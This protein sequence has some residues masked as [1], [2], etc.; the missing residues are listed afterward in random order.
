MTTLRIG[1]FNSLTLI[2]HESTNGHF[3]QFLVNHLKSKTFIDLEIIR[4]PVQRGRPPINSTR[5]YLNEIFRTLFMKT[6]GY[7]I[8]D[9]KVSLKNL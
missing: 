2:E 9:D 1:G 6:K 7:D 5:P 3:S 4:K 8:I